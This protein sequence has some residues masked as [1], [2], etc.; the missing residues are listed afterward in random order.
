[1]AKRTITMQ[2]PGSSGTIEVP[3]GGVASANHNG[4]VEVE[5]QGTLTIGGKVVAE[6]TD[7]NIDVRKEKD[8]T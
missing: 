1:M 7:F 2:H 6:I 8:E 5:K 3:P 4:W